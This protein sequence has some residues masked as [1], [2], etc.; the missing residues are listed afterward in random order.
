MAEYTEFKINDVRKNGKHENLISV[1]YKGIV[2]PGQYFIAWVAGFGDITLPVAF[3][4]D[5]TLGFSVSIKREASRKLFELRIKET[6]FLRG[7]YGHG[8]PMN[9]LKHKNLVMISENDLFSPIFAVI[10]FIELN[11]KEYKK[12]RVILIQGEDESD[13][14]LDLLKSID[15]KKEIEVIKLK[16]ISELKENILIN[17]DKDSAEYLLSFKSTRLKEIVLFLKERGISEKQILIYLNRKIIC[18]TGVCGA[19]AVFGVHACIDGPVFRAD[20]I[21]R[22]F[23]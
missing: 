3:Y 12:A 16:N 11:K 2:F 8:F 1:K 13:A 21:E 9:N 14:F 23:R 22:F 18:G 10:K 17:D 7:P 19:C 20:K 4:S 6:I 15:G 5:G